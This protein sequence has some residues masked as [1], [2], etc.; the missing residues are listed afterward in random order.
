MS[1]LQG[2]HGLLSHVQAAFGAVC[3]AAAAYAIYHNVNLWRDGTADFHGA[4]LFIWIPIGLALILV[5]FNFIRTAFRSLS[6]GRCPA[7][8][9]NKQ[10]QRT[11]TG[12]RGRLAQRAAAERRRWAFRRQHMI[13]LRFTLVAALLAGCSTAPPPEGPTTYTSYFGFT[14]QLLGQWLVLSPS[15][16]ATANAEESLQSLGIKHQSGSR[17][18]EFDSAARENRASRVLLRSANGRLRISKQ[19]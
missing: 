15:A 17:Q 18:S 10:L 2:Q 5:G 8:T 16:A 6:G 12:R 11:V 1:A 19:H 4:M 7:M 9:P 13:L 3:M 14:V